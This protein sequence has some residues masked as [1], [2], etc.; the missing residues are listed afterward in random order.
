MHS[1]NTRVGSG[2]EELA[3]RHLRT[4][5][6]RILGRNVHVGRLGEI[7]LIAERGGR[8]VFVEVKARFGS[9]Y[10]RP[11]EALTVAK[12]LHFRRAIQAWLLRRGLTGV[13]HRADV[14]A[15]DFAAMPPAVRHLE[16]VEL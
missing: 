8:I 7:D 6:Y 14:I 3:E 5:G 2:G 16:A 15:I 12:R 1:H 10:G 4:G 11:E 13:P 9:G